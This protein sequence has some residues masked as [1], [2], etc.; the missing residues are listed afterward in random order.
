MA[1]IYSKSGEHV[2][3]CA[4]REAH[5]RPFQATDWTDL[6]VGFFLS[7]CGS[8]DPADDDVITGLAETI[9]SDP[10]ALVPWTDRIAIGLTD[11]ATGATFLGYTNLHGGRITATGRS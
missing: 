5:I 8:A 10:N 4:V 6:R 1:K 2:I 3:I 9:G 7:L 11:S